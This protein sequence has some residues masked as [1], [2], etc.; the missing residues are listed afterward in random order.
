MVNIVTEHSDAPA[1][2]DDDCLWTRDNDGA[3]I[4]DCGS[5]I[6][7][8]SDP[9]GTGVAFCPFCGRETAFLLTVNGTNTRH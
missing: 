9:A 4:T 8:G 5:L 2:S 1:L 6:S 3:W 7:F